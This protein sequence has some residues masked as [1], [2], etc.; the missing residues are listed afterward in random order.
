MMVCMRIA[1]LLLSLILIGAGV[2]LI[3][4]QPDIN[5]IGVGSIVI[6]TGLVQL[7]TTA[8]YR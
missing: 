7:V 2:A 8:I 4:A 3:F 6:A 1:S 5:E